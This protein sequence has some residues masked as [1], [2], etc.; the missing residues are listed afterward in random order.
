[1]SNIFLNVKAWQLTWLKRAVLKP[2]S[3]WV[4]INNEMLKNITFPEVISN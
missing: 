2:Y 1:M 4:L 3:T